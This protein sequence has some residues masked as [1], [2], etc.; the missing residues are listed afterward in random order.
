MS[1]ERGLSAKQE[2]FCVAVEIDGLSQ[3]QAYIK[4]YGRGNYSDE[5]I[6]IKA[7]RLA[8]RD[9][10]RIRLEELRSTVQDRASW[11]KLDMVKSLKEIAEAC[12]SAVIPIYDKDGELIKEKV[13]AAS[14]GVAVKAIDTAAKLLGYNAPQKMEVSGAIQVP[15]N[16]AELTTEELRAIAGI[17]VPECT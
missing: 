2:A 12:K 13:D 5:S 8:K 15:E 6:D 4:A 7:C 1:D 11:S 9:K 17:T 14:R 3:R 16:I 10:V